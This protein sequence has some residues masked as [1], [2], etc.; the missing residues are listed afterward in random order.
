VSSACGCGEDII[1]PTNPKL[2]FKL[3]DMEEMATAIL[4]L[5]SQNYSRKEVQ[6][7]V[8]GYDISEC[9]KTAVKLYDKINV[10]LEISE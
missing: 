10:T 8:E 3:G 9:V 4:E 1:S 6:E 7:Q 2:R 5:Y